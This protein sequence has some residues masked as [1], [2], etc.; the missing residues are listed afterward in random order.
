[1]SRF[2]FLT[3]DL[4]PR[5][6]RNLDPAWSSAVVRLLRRVIP[7]GFAWPRSGHRPDVLPVNSYPPA[8]RAV[9]D[10]G[11]DSSNARRR[12]RLLLAGLPRTTRTLPQP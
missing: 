6:P 11:N 10:A 7:V 4:Q 9:A 5:P 2:S 3:N 8:L 12:I 1:V